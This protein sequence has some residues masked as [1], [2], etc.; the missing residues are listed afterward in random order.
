MVQIKVVLLLWKVINTVSMNNSLVEYRVYKKNELARVIVDWTL[1][2]Q[3]L[4][5]K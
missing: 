2:L 1:L 3:L 4:W 5:F